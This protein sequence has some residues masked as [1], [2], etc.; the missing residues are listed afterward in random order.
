MLTL[1]SAV[2]GLLAATSGVSGAPVKR[3]GTQNITDISVLQYALTLE[4]I[5]NAF[6]VSGLTKYDDQAFLDAGFP[7]W[8]RG[9][10]QQ[11]GDH[12]ADHVAFLTTAIEASGANATQAC[13][14]SYPYTDVASFVTMSASIENVGTAAYLGSAHYLTSKT[15]LNAAGSI[16]ATEARQAAWIASAALKGSPW[17]TDFQTP[18]DPSGVYSIASQFIVPGS[19]PATNPPLFVKPFPAATVTP[20][21]PTPGSQITI[22]LPTGYPG[23]SNST[24]PLYVAYYS[25]LNIYSSEIAENGTTT[26]PDELV[27]IVFAAVVKEKPSP[28]NP[29]TDDTTLSGLVNWDFGVP[30]NARQIFD[31]NIAPYN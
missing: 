7:A 26:I 16:L 28:T 9:R 12:E 27:G 23:P 2:V 6:Y 10:I 4:H 13:S 11:I 20:A 21:T 3:A 1:A 29:P 30:S 22:S 19:C 25:G 14:Y 31:T 24:V 8:V 18:L 17:E 15:N 5:E